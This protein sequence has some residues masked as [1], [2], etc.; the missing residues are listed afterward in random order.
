MRTLIRTPSRRTPEQLSRARANRAW[1]NALRKRYPATKPSSTSGAHA[2]RTA[3]ALAGDGPAEG[4]QAAIRAH[5]GRYEDVIVREAREQGVP[6]SLV[7]AVIEMESGFRNIFGRDNGSNPNPIRSPRS[8]VLEVTEGRYRRYLEYCRAGKDRNGVGPMQLTWHTFQERAD[9]LGGCWKPAINIK[10]GVGL[11]ASNIKARGSVRAGVR[12]YNGSGP[13]AERYADKVLARQRV[14]SARLAGAGITKPRPIGTGERAPRVFKITRPPLSG[15]DVK[16][17][18]DVLNRRL[19]RWDIDLQIEEDGDY[20]PRTRQTARRVLRGLG[21]AP[22]DYEHGIT[23]A[24]RG[25][26]RTPTRRS[27]A[28]LERARQNRPWLK[29]LRKRYAVSGA[30]AARYPLGRRGKLIGR[31]HQGTH[32]LGNRQSDNAV[33][34]GV[35]VGTTMLALDDGE[36]VKVSRHAQDGS[37]FAGDAITIRGDRGN[38]YFYK[39]GVASVRVGQ[40]VKRGQVIGTTGSASGSPH[41]HLGFMKGDPLRIIGQSR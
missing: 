1:K 27:A 34:L 19:A 3:P 35:A 8:G 5:R 16:A 9:R 38:S 39:H 4:L 23:P 6:V 20:G 40:R 15:D 41:L 14:W 24:L 33:D 13:D 21:V 10:V 28:Q 36:V 37:R 18:Q 17:F 12:A 2:G 32:S 22:A 25:L 26:I 31:P 30:A 11:L 29:A 7:C